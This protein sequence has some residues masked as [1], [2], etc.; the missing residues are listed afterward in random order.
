MRIRNSLP[1]DTPESR[2]RYQENYDRT[3]GRKPEPGYV[4]VMWRLRDS[5]DANELSQWLDG[6][7]SGRHIRKPK[8]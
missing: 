4:N 5:M 1:G 2:R 7:W 8:L 6:D 3:F